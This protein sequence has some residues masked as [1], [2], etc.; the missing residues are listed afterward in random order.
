MYGTV[1][2]FRVLP[3]KEQEIMK[4][5]EEIARHPAEGQIADY[6]FK[7]D[8]GNDE[9]IIVALFSDRESYHRNAQNPD[10]DRQYQQL[11][12]LLAADPEWN[13]GDV[14]SIEPAA[15]PL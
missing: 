9:Y 6:V 4:F 7:L 13:D 11:R 15:V 2:R 10:T 1:A 8:K 12:A 3:G 14:Q 5:S